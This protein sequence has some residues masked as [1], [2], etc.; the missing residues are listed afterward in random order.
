MINVLVRDQSSECHKCFPLPFH[1]H[2]LEDARIWQRVL[3]KDPATLLRDAE[4]A[5]FSPGSTVPGVGDSP[6]MQVCIFLHQNAQF[7]RVGVTLHHVLGVI[8]GLLWLY[9][10]CRFEKSAIDLRPA[11]S[12][13]R[14]SLARCVPILAGL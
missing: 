9:I 11:H 4:Q 8:D 2:F 3:S 5:A 12:P 14:L 1:L 10:V 13:L 6:N 7:C